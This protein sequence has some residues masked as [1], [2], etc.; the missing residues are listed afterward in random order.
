MYDKETLCEKIRQL[1]PD[2]GACG[3]DLKVSYDQI[4]KHWVVE[5]RK[6]NQYL[7]HYLPTE[8]ADTCM[9]GKQCVSLGLEIAQLKDN[10]TR[11]A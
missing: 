11:Q 7:K 1:Y 4:Q 10:I 3:L 8:D 9:D 6:D 2:I 5:L